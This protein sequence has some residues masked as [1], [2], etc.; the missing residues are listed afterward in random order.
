MVTNRV[1]WNRKG[2]YLA[3]FAGVLA[4]FLGALIAANLAAFV[5]G[6]V[7]NKSLTWCAVCGTL[8]VCT[9]S[10][11]FPR[12]RYEAYAVILYAPPAFLGAVLTQRVISNFVRTPFATPALDEA[13]SSLLEHANLVGQVVHYSALTLIGH[14]AGMGSACE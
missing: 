6:V 9:C 11:S 5:T 10:L 3:G 8:R 2:V 13:E 7:M 1:D 4:S 14:A 12:F